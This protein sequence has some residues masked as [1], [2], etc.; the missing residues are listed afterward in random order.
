MAGCTGVFAIA[1]LP[2]HS[3]VPDLLLPLISDLLLHPAWL[4]GA[5]LG[6]DSLDEA[7]ATTL[8]NHSEPL[9]DLR[10]QI[11][12]VRYQTEF[13]T[14]FYGGDFAQQVADFQSIQEVLGEI[15]DYSI[16]KDFMGDFCTQIGTNLYRFWHS[17]LNMNR[18]AYGKPGSRF[19]SAILIQN[20]GR[21]CDRSCCKFTCRKAAMRWLWAVSRRDCA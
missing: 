14:Q 12:R 7:I 19:S 21:N 1:A 5:E 13:F 6:T 16:L 3:A 17:G 9:H 20:F 2:I 15:Q 10:K 18:L 8:R 4:V 11:K